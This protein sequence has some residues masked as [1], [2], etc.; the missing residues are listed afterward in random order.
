MAAELVS[1][2]PDVLMCGSNSAYLKAATQTIPIVFMFVPDPVGAK[3]VESL[4]RP[5]GNMTGL[6]NFGRDI[7][8]KRLQILKEIVPG[9]S[10]VALLINSNQ[11]S[12]G[13]Y[14]DVMNAAAKELELVIATFD[15]RTSEEL[16]PA[17][18]DMTKAGME[19]M[20][21]KA[22]RLFSG[23]GLFR[24][25]Q[26]STVFRYVLIH[27]KR[28]STAHSCPMDPIRSKHVIGQPH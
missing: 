28:L 7:A 27:K 5:G 13:M 23:D 15:V 24:N 10:R 22:E 17:F 19:A 9:L 12:T 3:F 6:S 16:E 8:G 25:W 2:N 14:I 20:T 4:A 21:P 26:W 11:Q 1:L 18:R